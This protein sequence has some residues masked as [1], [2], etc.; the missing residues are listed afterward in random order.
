MDSLA[1]SPTTANQDLITNCSFSLSQE[2][3]P[4]TSLSFNQSIWNY[5]ASTSGGSDGKEFACNAGD[6]GSIP[7]S[8]KSP[9]EGNGYP[10]QYSHLE[11]FIDRGAWQAI[12]Y[13]VAKGWTRLGEFHFTM[14]TQ[15]QRRDLWTQW[16]KESMGQ[17]ERVAVKHV[18]YHM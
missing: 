7:G 10:L 1:L 11:N 6:P 17:I 3:N 13:G 16:G 18:H 9:G 4:L 5:L 8:G 14:E 15:T 12:V 2:N